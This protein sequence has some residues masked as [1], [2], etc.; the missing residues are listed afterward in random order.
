VQA[1]QHGL[2]PR[3][4]RRGLQS[5]RPGHADKFT[6]TLGDFGVV[7]AK[8]V[9]TDPTEESYEAEGTSAEGGVGWVPGLSFSPADSDYVTV[10]LLAAGL[11]RIRD[12][13]RRMDAGEYLRRT[14]AEQGLLPVPWRSGMVRLWWRFHSAGEQPPASDL[15]LMDLCR[16][17]FAQWP[18][19]LRLSAADQGTSLLDGDELTLL[20]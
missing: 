13:R 8:T 5:G 2:V 6:R 17:P 14:S 16:T 15:E 18:V 19:R 11:A 10:M 7:G 20:A 12:D 1:V 9:V 4:W 3:S